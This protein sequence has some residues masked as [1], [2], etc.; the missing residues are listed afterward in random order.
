MASEKRS[1]GKSP[2]WFWWVNRGYGDLKTAV[3]LD[4]VGNGARARRTGAGRF[5]LLIA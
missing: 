5:S 3:D 2:G 1:S 4:L